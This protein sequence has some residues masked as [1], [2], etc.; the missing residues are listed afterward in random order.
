M[1]P[2]V[3]SPERETKTGASPRTSPAARRLDRI[4]DPVVRFFTSLR[5]T[6][7]CLAFGLVLVFFG[8]MAQDPIGLYLAQEKFFRS[9]FVGAAPMWAAIKKTLE[10][11]H[12]YLPPS[13]AA[14]V[15]FGSKLPVFPGGYLI[16][17]VLLINLIASHFKRF[18]FTANKAGIWMVHAGLIN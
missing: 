15:V 7:A 5:L 10:M 8:T 13:T 11:L 6:V 9:F 17:G 2:S 18:A 16:G 14:D 4:L 3:P 12:I 1:P